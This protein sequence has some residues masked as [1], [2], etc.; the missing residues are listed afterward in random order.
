MGLIYNLNQKMAR[1]I[2]LHQNFSHIVK[3]A[4]IK[5]GILY[6]KYKRHVKDL[7]FGQRKCHTHVQMHY[8]VSNEPMN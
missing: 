1:K 2:E 7:A 3:S 8:S 4:L 5:L 6:L